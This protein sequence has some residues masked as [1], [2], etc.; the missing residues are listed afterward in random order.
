[1]GF[2]V[3]I[4]MMWFQCLQP[5]PSDKGRPMSGTWFHPLPRGGHEELDKKIICYYCYCYCDVHWSLFAAKA[6]GPEEA[7]GASCRTNR[8]PV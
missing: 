4:I 3:L 8:S 5:K 7:S 6:V 1:M 2:I